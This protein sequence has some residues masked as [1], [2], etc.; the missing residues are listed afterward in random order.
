MIPSLSYLKS[1][2]FNLE[3][4]KV[5]MYYEHGVANTFHSAV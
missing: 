3:L 5:C 4:F 1:N 2:L